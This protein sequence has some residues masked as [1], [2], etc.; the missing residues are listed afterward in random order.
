MDY[1][2]QNEKKALPSPQTET[3]DVPAQTIAP[4][5]RELPALFRRF[6]FTSDDVDMLNMRFLEYCSHVFEGTETTPDYMIEEMFKNIHANY[7]REYEL[8]DSKISVPI[9]EE[10]FKNRTEGKLH[11]PKKRFRLFK[12]RFGN[13]R[14]AKY[15]YREECADAD[16][17]FADRLQV[18]FVNYPEKKSWWRRRAERRAAKRAAKQARKQALRERPLSVGM[19][20]PR[21]E[22]IAEDTAKTAENAV[23]SAEATR[24]AEQAIPGD[25]NP[26]SPPE[27]QK[28]DTKED[29]RQVQPPAPPS[30]TEVNGAEEKTD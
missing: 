10:I 23:C 7:M 28:Q 25:N 15:I 2:D 30:E 14:P 26:P 1:I 20:M 22:E 16:R 5:K 3:V 9:S 18:F 4:A 24:Q 29:G 6:E 13:N 8:L 27:G 11:I 12:W 21:D 19:E 17:T